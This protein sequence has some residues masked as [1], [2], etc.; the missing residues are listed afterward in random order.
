MI[1]WKN[2]DL[3]YHDFKF[4]RTF[5]PKMMNLH[6]RSLMMAK[7]FLK[8]SMTTWKCSSSMAYRISTSPCQR[9]RRVSQMTAIPSST[10]PRTAVSLRTP[11]RSRRESSVWIWCFLAPTL[12]RTLLVT[13]LKTTSSLKCTETSLQS[14]TEDLMARIAICVIF[15]SSESQIKEYILWACLLELII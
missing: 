6:L 13:S 11:H 2:T 12:L 15:Q 1:S 9:L 5:R 10:P 8:P 3:K 4:L 7:K 14:L